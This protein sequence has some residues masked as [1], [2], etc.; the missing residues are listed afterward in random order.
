M[1]QAVPGTKS[2]PR[3]ED[4]PDLV[5]FVGSGEFS[6]YFSKYREIL[7]VPVFSS[8]HIPDD[9]VT[10]LSRQDIFVVAS[11][12]FKDGSDNTYREVSTVELI[13]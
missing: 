7:V 5:D 12:T 1:A 4:V 2:S 9:L 3:S 8:L 13:S 6:L 10:S 11:C